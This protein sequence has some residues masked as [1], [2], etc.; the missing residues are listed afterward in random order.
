M[1]RLRPFI[2][3]LSV[4]VGVGV[5]YWIAYRPSQSHQ[6][7]LRREISDLQ[8]SIASLEISI[9]D[10]SNPGAEQIFPEGLVW[11][12]ETQADATLALQDAVIDLVGQFGITLITFGASDL[13]RETTQ[14]MMAFELEA[15]GPLAQTHAFLAALEALAPQAAVGSLRMRPVQSYGN[16]TLGDISVYSQ[17]T[18]WAFWGDGS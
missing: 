9:A 8:Y 16:E 11:G 2:S 10:L 14:G 3:F 13:R 15:E 5:C 7:A 1:I 6:E 18:L 12:A 17:I 4:L